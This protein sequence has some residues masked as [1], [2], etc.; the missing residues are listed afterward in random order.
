MP[1]K[2]HEL[3]ALLRAERGSAAYR[4]L[5]E[6]L[7]LRMRRFAEQ[8]IDDVDPRTAGKASECRDLLK[9]LLTVDVDDTMISS[10]ENP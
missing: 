2:E 7:Q 5:I 1:N 3:F 4:S 10:E 9:R 6:L 8:L